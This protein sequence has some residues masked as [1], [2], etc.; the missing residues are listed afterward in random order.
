M[1]Y[2]V[3]FNGGS[4]GGEFSRFRHKLNIVWELAGHQLQP[5]K[6]FELAYDSDIGGVPE[7]GVPPNHPF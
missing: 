5:L 1:M 6:Q 3:R 7:I 4:S 2:V